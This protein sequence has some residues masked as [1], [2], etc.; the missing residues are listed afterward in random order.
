MGFVAAKMNVIAAALSSRG[1]H[2]SIGQLREKGAE[3]CGRFELRHRIE[4]LEGA[5]KSFEIALC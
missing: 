1:D 5:G 4:L 3:L 2:E